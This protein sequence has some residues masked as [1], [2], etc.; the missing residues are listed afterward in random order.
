MILDRDPIGPGA[1]IRDIVA[2][3]LDSAVDGVQR[4]SQSLSLNI[5]LSQADN[6]Q[7]IGGPSSSVHRIA[8]RV[9]RRNLQVSITVHLGG[10]PRYAVYLVG[11]TGQRVN[12]RVN[13]NAYAHLSW[14][15]GGVIGHRH[16]KIAGHQF[17]GFIET[18]FAT[19]KGCRGIRDLVLDCEKR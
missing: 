18:G 5:L 14:R 19:V 10:D 13:A 2:E 15:I 7:E 11:N 3:T 16:R 6:V 12:R 9:I 4:R 1:E 17:I 8:V